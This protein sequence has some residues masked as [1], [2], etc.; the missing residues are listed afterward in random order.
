MPV[1]SKHESHKDVQ[2]QIN[3]LQHVR[4][5]PE[6]DK[7]VLKNQNIQNEEKKTEIEILID[8]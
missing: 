7:V 6:P 1:I 8:D 5:T 2:S 3:D 4:R